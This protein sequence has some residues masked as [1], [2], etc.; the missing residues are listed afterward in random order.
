MSFVS[1]Y[2]SSPTRIETRFFYNPINI[3]TLEINQRLKRKYSKPGIYISLGLILSLLML[4]LFTRTDLK[5]VQAVLELVGLF[6]E[7]FD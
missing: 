7:N 5:V 4:L 3:N 6:I 1:E 2:L